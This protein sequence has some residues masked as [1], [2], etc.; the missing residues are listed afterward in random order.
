MYG[1]NEDMER[2]IESLMVWE[3]SPETL[4]R[5]RSIYMEFVQSFADSNSNPL[6][7]LTRNSIICEN[8]LIAA[9]DPICTFGIPQED[10]RE[11]QNLVRAEVLHSVS[12]DEEGLEEFDIYNILRA[13]SENQLS[14]HYLSLLK[15]G[16]HL[17][18][19]GKEVL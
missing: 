15:N 5:Y 4:R 11:I 7:G 13:L 19:K 17:L 6:F 12:N 14:K 8:L 18:L 10:F 1:W 2:G 16:F 9:N 3:D